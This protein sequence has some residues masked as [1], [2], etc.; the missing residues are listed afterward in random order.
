[1]NDHFD[2]TLHELLAKHKTE[3]PNNG[4]SD[5]VLKKLPLTHRHT[6]ILYV[7]YTLGILVFVL[8]GSYALIIKRVSLFVL[9]VSTCNVPS[10]FSVIAMLSVVMIYWIL[11]KITYDE[12]FV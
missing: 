5:N 6:W 8:S 4:F 9:Y 1:M 11:A 12:N 7:A 10:I 3:I 2:N